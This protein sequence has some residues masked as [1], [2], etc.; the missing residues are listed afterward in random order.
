MAV[1]P[2]VPCGTTKKY[3]VIRARK[4]S[5]SEGAASNSRPQQ[6][7][8]SAACKAEAGERLHQ[9]MVKM[10]TATQHIA[11]K[12]ASHPWT[13]TSGCKGTKAPTA[14]ARIPTRGDNP[15]ASASTTNKAYWIE[16]Q[17]ALKRCTESV[18]SPPVPNSRNKRLTNQG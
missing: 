6:K 3:S 1:R 7:P 17:T 18:P 8:T 5:N 16:A 2:R 12:L 9:S 14:P 4:T 15:H 13:S 10:R 11:T